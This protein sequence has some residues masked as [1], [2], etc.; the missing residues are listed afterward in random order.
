MNKWKI[1]LIA[2]GWAVASQAVLISGNVNGNHT[3]GKPAFSAGYTGNGW[4]SNTGWTEVNTNSPGGTAI[5]GDA[6]NRGLWNAVN[7][8]AG[9]SGAVL[10]LVFSYNSTIGFDVAVW[11]IT[12][13]IPADAAVP[14]TQTNGNGFR[15]GVTGQN[16]N[17]DFSGLSLGVV[18]LSD[19]S[20]KDASGGTANFK[21]GAALTVPASAG[22]TTWSTTLNLSTAGF[23]DIQDLDVIGINV[24]NSSGNAGVL[25]ES[26]TV[27]VIPEPAT[28][29]IVS[30]SGLAIL[31]VR[32][33][34]MM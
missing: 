1:A 11:G 29:G 33:R 6:A 27:N 2:T 25:I 21:P 31:F 34:F 12:N 23:S 14:L 4:I 7:V 16:F 8:G 32:R 3:S 20:G 22:W 26:V 24:G 18:D 30:A 17:G 13:V 19:G 9:E 28:L 10:Q 15:Y 5:A